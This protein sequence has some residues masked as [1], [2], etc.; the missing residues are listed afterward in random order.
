MNIWLYCPESKECLVPDVSHINYL[1]YKLKCTSR[2][3]L[4]LL[5]I[6][7]QRLVLNLLG[8][9]GSSYGP[10]SISAEVDRQ[11][12]II[13]NACPEWWNWDRSKPV[14]S[15]KEYNDVEIEMVGLI[16]TGAFAES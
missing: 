2:F 13:G 3:A 14:H 15:E 8:L 7:G 9:K 16:E 1:S 4:N 11:L 10:C 5:A 12:E 6:A